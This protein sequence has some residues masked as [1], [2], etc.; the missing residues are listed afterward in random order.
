MRFI[1]TQTCGFL[2]YILFTL[3]SLNPWI[4]GYNYGR[5]E[6]WLPFGL[7]VTGLIYSMFTDYESAIWRKI[8]VR[9]HLALNFIGGSFLAFS[10]WIFG[11]SQIVWIP[12]VVFGVL[13]IALSLFTKTKSIP[14]ITFE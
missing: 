12:F 8:G 4:F 7:G 9:T 5:M 3:L 10:P 11:F 2:E 14:G 13:E 6:T 1:P